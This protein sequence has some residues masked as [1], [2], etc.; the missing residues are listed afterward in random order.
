MQ[1]SIRIE[2]KRRRRVLGVEALDRP[3]AGELHVHE[4]PHLPRPGGE[5]LVETDDAARVAGAGAEPP[6][7]ARVHAVVQRQLQHLHQVEVAG[8]DVGLLA[9]RARLHAAA[10]AASRASSRLLPWRSNS[11]TTASALKTEGKP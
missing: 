10:G 4:V 1:S 6:A 9:E 2:R 3:V 7:G 8:Q 5:Q 11:A